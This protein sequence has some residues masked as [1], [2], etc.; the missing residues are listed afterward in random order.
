MSRSRRYYFFRC[1][2]R[3]SDEARPR[4][5]RRRFVVAAALVAMEAVAGVRIDVDLAVAAALRLDRLDI[6]HRDAL[7]LLAEMHLHRH[8]RLLVG[9]LRDLAAVVGDRA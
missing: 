1:F 5:L 2:F 3:K 9:E 6:R 4:G 7:V 8:L